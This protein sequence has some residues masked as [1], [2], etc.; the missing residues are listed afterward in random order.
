ME[1]KKAVSEAKAILFEIR[2]LEKKIEAHQVSICKLAVSVCDIRHGGISKNLYT[3]TDFA[4]DIGMH[5][6]TLQNWLACYR[7][8]VEKLEEGVFEESDKDWSAARKTQRDINERQRSARRDAGLTGTR[9]KPVTVSPAIIND[10]FKKYKNDEK[11]FVNEYRHALA[12]EKHLKHLLKHRDM[13]LVSDSQWIELM[14][15]LDE[16]SD[17]INQYLTKKRKKNLRKV[18]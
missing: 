1:Y 13:S 12:S 15:I 5:K 17:K 4:N 16:N 10:T 11:P 18:G 8:V 6:K 7:G 9:Q 2:Q 14:E 3:I